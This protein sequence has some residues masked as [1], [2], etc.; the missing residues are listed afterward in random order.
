[1]AGANIN[2]TGVQATYAG[3]SATNTTASGP[4]GAGSSYTTVVTFSGASPQQGSSYSIDV[5]ITYRNL[6]TGI[7]GF[8]SS[9]SVTG[10]VS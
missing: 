6:D 7:S 9:G 3:A 10:T 5:T 4:L 8:I 1:M 2:I